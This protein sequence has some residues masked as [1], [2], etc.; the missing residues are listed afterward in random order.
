MN[1]AKFF[2]STIVVC[3]GVIG[4]ALADCAAQEVASIDLTLAVES[5]SLRRPSA[6]DED[7]GPRSGIGEVREGTCT[8]KSSTV[9][10]LQRILVS[11]DRASYSVGDQP[12]FVVQVKNAGSQSIKVPFLSD[13]ASLQ[14]A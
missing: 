14:P 10:T 7:G 5:T 9:G 1:V 13:L 3:L 11:L 2:G 8:A 4:T 12:R 6:T